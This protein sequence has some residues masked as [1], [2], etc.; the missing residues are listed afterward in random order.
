MYEL[1]LLIISRAPELRARP[2]VELEAARVSYPPPTL[3][4]RVLAPEGAAGFHVYRSPYASLLLPPEALRGMP[5]DAGEPESV[6]VLGTSRVLLS[7]ELEELLFGGG[8]G[9]E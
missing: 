1:L 7:K 4:Y 2:R 9:G 6:R 5:G 3:G 8:G